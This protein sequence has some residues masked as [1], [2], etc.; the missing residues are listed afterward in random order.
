MA[1]SETQVFTNAIY[2]ILV[3]TFYDGFK[4]SNFTF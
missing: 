1:Q 3:Y 2:I 4:S